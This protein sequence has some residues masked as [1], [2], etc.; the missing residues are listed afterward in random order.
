MGLQ[1]IN[2]SGLADTK[3]LA[4][5]GVFPLCRAGS[6]PC[7]SSRPRQLGSGALPKFLVMSSSLALPF[8]ST[9]GL[10]S[11]ALHTELQRPIQPADAAPGGQPCAKA[12]LILN[13]GGDNSL[14]PQHSHGSSEGTFG[15]YT[16]GII[17]V[18]P[19]IGQGGSSA[20]H[21][22]PPAPHLP[23]VCFSLNSLPSSAFCSTIGTPPHT[24]P[25]PPECRQASVQ[26]RSPPPPSL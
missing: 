26:C 7:G 22:S 16:T 18:S 25:H 12:P 13:Q 2:C 4:A 17:L 8:T 11:R 9:W 14:L 19:F 5:S 23:V 24:H 21:A 1:K 15:F 20:C 10:C 6:S 3:S